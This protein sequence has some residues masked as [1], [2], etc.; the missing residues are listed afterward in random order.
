MVNLQASLIDKYREQSWHIIQPQSRQWCCR[1]VMLNFFAQF[2]HNF[3]D[4]P[5]SQGTS[6]NT[7]DTFGLFHGD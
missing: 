5:S 3:T 7:S 2:G 1:L 6:C 4:D